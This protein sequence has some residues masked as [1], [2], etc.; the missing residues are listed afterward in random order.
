MNNQPHIN[1]PRRGRT[2]RAAR[3]VYTVITLLC[4]IPL[5][6]QAGG[7]AGQG[8]RFYRD[9]RSWVEETSG[10]M[11]PARTLKVSTDC[12]NI[13][14]HGSGAQTITYVIKKRSYVS[15]E[16][17]A[18]KQ[19][20]RYR[21]TATR[22]SDTAVIEARWMSGRSERF[23]TDIS[24]EVPRDMALVHLDTQGGNLGVTGTT[25]RV[26]LDTQGGNVSV[27]DVG[28][29]H[30]NTQGG[31]VTADMVHGD[32]QI[33]SGGGN[34]SVGES[35]G[36]GEINTAGGNVS[37]KSM[38]WGMVQTGGGSIDIGQSRG[39]LTAETGGGSI[40]VNEVQGKASLQT[41]G[42]NIRLGS[43]RGQVRASTAGGSI[44]MWKLYQ[45]AQAQTGAG[46]ITVEFLG[47]RGAFSDSMLR[48][49]AGNV[50]VYLGSGVPCTIH[51]SAELASGQ[52]IRTDFPEIKVTSEG[53]TYGPRSMNAEG[54]V[55][56]GGPPIKIRTTIGQIDIRKA[57]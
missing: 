8:T 55:N 56:G 32:T 30:V 1:S 17:E 13:R 19:F 47:G 48:T 49:A 28:P 7:G 53:G 5:M 23:N 15:S 21:I 46:A 24:V 31:N 4:S 39:D 9:G 25:A 27:A 42:G 11:T 37:V 57:K 36:K 51:A 12:G 54:A 38:A 35:Q 29:V 22:N 40:D 33:N 6:A 3:Y 50:I 44:E 34:I 26:D 18:R 45:G 2:R 14:V 10:T 52:G 16:A 41:G 43:A 20:E